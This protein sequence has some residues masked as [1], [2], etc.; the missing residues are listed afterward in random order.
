[1]TAKEQLQR[2][3]I[4]WDSATVTQVLKTHPA[5]EREAWLFFSWISK[6]FKHDQ[7]TYTTMLDIF[8]EARRIKFNE[9]CLPAYAGERIKVDA[10]AYTLMLH[11]LSN[12]RLVTS[13]EQ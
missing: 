12:G 2:L 5:I 1:M 6:G 3:H 7:L 8:D 4:R 9:V 10:I 13:K 11:W